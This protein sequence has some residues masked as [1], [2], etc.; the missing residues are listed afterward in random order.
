MIE[1]S[2][3]KDYANKLM[4]DMD[5]K[6]Y[7]TLQQEFEVIQKQMDLIGEIEELK[8]VEPMTFPF[9]LEEISLRE[10][11]NGRVVD[12]SEAFNNCHDK[13]GRD[14]RVPRVVE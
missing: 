8:N 9:K 6:E 4:F 11:S 2:K 10:D 3:L 14:V 7:E 13:K 12:N 5:E 1:K